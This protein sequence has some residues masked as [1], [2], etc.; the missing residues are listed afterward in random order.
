MGYLIDASSVESK[1]YVSEL[2]K[3]DKAISADV[4][5]KGVQLEELIF[6]NGYKLEHIFL[7]GTSL[8]PPSATGSPFRYNYNLKAIFEALSLVDFK[9][10]LVLPSGDRFDPAV[11]HITAV[12]K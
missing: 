9:G 11:E 2:K 7:D 4:V 3:R 6:N 8:T 5:Q 12:A 10:K 1:E